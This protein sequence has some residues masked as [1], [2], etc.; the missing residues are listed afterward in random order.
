M[1]YLVSMLLVLRSKLIFVEQF[2][3]LFRKLILLCYSVNFSGF[4]LPSWEGL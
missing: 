1:K 3:N 4:Q 2:L